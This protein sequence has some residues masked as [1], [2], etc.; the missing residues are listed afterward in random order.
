MRACEEAL[1]REEV[2]GKYHKRIR[3]RKDVVV[4]KDEECAVDWKPV[5]A[6]SRKVG[7]FFVVDKGKK[8]DGD[9]GASKI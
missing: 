7:K 3:R 1:E 4:E 6:A 2:V 5:D 8:V 9:D